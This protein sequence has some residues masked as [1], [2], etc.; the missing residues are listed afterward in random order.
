MDMLSIRICQCPHVSGGID[1]RNNNKQKSY[2]LKC[3]KWQSFFVRL[4]Q[5]EKKLV[6]KYWIHV[7]VLL[8]TS[9]GA[10]TWVSVT[11]AVLGVS[12]LLRETL[13][14]SSLVWLPSRSLLQGW[15]TTSGRH[16]NIQ[17]WI[18]INTAV[19]AVVAAA[20]GWLSNM[21]HE[22]SLSESILLLSGI[23]WRYFYKGEYNGC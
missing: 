5:R 1:I 14:M 22:R 8:T 4:T 20:A 2:H 23:S 15:Y 16:M 13:Y 19:V 6:C 12:G 9:R 11:A 7:V 3:F 18:S 10:L 17:A 21:D